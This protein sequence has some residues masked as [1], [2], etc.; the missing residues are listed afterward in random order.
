MMSAA[1][2]YVVLFSLSLASPDARLVGICTRLLPRIQGQIDYSV[3][4]LK[5]GNSNVLHSVTRKRPEDGIA[6][7]R[8]L[9]REFGKASTLALDRDEE[10]AVFARLAECEVAPPLISTFDGG[11]IEGWLNGA[12]CSNTECR[13]PTVYTAV[14]RELARLHSFPT[15]SLVSKLPPSDYCWGWATAATWLEGARECERLL[16]QSQGMEDVD[17]SLIARVRAIDL[18]R[19]ELGLSDLRGHLERHPGLGN[20]C[21]CH[22]DL[23]NTNV[24][25]D[26]ASGTTR[27]ID[28]E[29]GGINLRG[30]DL[31]T[32]LSH[33]AGGAV[34]GRYNHSAFP[35]VTERTAFLTSYAEAAAAASDGDEAVDGL[36][37]QLLAETR[38]AAPLAHCV[39]GLWALCA[40]PDAMASG[41]GGGRFSHIEYAERRLAAFE[42]SLPDAMSAQ[43]GA[44][45]VPRPRPVRAA[46]PPTNKNKDKR[47][48]TARRGVSDMFR[49]DR[50]GSGFTEGTRW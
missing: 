19:I 44:T 23:S 34:D 16:K 7:D 12:P 36:V 43:C 38:F 20:R 33:W 18:D 28:F 4:R 35:S 31:A 29:F 10:N 27:I 42:H 45:S 32:H 22:N 47:T 46:R 8:F 9:V 3:E 24:H 6:V 39:W 13:T 48:S 11:R 5:M 15:E 21:Y 14:A 37:A 1:V 50:L 49:P 26:A 17:P 41:A 30:F 25:R 2:H 40:L